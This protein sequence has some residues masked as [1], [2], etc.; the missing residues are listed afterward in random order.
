MLRAWLDGSYRPPSTQETLQLVGEKCNSKVPAAGTGRAQ[1]F[2]TETCSPDLARAGT[3][4]W[5]RG[6]TEAPPSHTDLQS[7]RDSLS[8]LPSE[9]PAVKGHERGDS[10][11]QD[12][13]EDP[14]SLT[15]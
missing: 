3:A 8:H 7:T 13:L 14:G 4:S 10:S 1:E 6:L 5:G 12:V 9:E 2:R 15:N 11:E